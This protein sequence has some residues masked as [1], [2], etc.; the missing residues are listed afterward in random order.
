MIKQF[1][2]HFMPPTALKPYYQNVKQHD[3]KN[4]ATIAKLLKKYDFDQPIVVDS[5]NV[6]IKGH[7]RY[8]AALFLNKKLVPVIIRD[9]LTPEQAQAARIA[10]N[11]IFEL[12]E[13]DD[14]MVRA[15]L[16]DFVKEGGT[17]AEEIFD[18][19][20]V[21]A[22]KEAQAK[23]HIEVSSD[24]LPAPKG[25]MQVCPKCNYTFWEEKS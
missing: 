20:K 24:D 15:E 22:P 12:G 16:A 17:G 14:G 8:M 10:D 19:M 1:P 11:R 7:G 4:V 23:M 18:F 9:D 2:I 21:T 3:R 5:E 6:I 25:S 13:I